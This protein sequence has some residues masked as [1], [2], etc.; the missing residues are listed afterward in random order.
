VASVLSAAGERRREARAAPG[1][2]GWEAEAVLRPG[3]SVRVL[4]L[5]PGGALVESST[6]VR[7]E[8]TTELQLSAERG[9]AA[10]RAYV[11]GCWVDGLAPLRYRARLVFDVRLT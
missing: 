4:D 6:A 7:P 1:A 10:V 11:A 2:L 3:L 8:S 9:R 5:S